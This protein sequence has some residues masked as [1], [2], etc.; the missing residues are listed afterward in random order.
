M[1]YIGKIIPGTMEKT[2]DNSILEFFQSYEPLKIEM[3]SE[4][5]EQNHLKTKVLDSFISGEMK[6]MVRTNENVISRDC[7][8]LDLDDV[9]VT[10]SELLAAIH[11]KF[12]KFQYIAYPSLSHGVKGVRYRLILPLSESV[13]ERDY[14]L[15]IQYMNIKVFENLIGKAD[16][17]NG[18]WSQAML[19]PV[20]T[21]YIQEDSLVINEAEY[22]LPVENLLEGAKAWYKIY[23]P[24]FYPTTYYFRSGGTRYRNRTTELF[25][26]LTMGC[27][28]GNRNN[29][30][31][32]ITGGLLARAVNVKE[33]YKLVLVANQH[34][35]VPLSIQEVEH[36]FYSIAERE[37]SD[38]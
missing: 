14:K 4:K 8:I 2:S 33:A 23:K 34:F 31:A 22:K 26:S 9:L 16:E 32:Q 18:V 12:E 13:T 15:L 20:V 3:P 7:L 6:E 30:I 36:T 11:R 35:D 19:L 25:E 1:I 21:Q 17:S 27:S 10:E 5:E 37:L 24:P 28:E 29:R 38:D